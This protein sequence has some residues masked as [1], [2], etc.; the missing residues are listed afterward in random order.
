METIAYEILKQQ[1]AGCMPSRVG[2]HWPPFISV[3]HLHLHAIAPE[4][5]LSIRPRI[6]FQ[7]GTRWFLTTKEVIAKIRNKRMI[8]SL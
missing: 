6:L 5:E 7:P 8:S 2:Y 1:G 3:A 4:K